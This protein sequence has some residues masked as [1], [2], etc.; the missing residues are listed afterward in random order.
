ML[1]ETEKLLFVCSY[2]APYG[3]NFIPSL[4]A[5]EAKLATRGVRCVYAFPEEAENRS[6]IAELKSKGKEIVYI[7][8]HLSRMRFV[9]KL[10]IIVK[11]KQVN[12]LYAHF[13]S[14]L[15][16]EIFANLH[17][18]IRVFIHIHSDFSA[19][20]RSWKQKIQ[21][22][23]LYKLF[24]SHVQFFSVSSA[25]VDYN[26]KKIFHVP[27]GL[28]KDRLTCEHKGGISVREQ[29]HVADNEILCEIFGWS[30]FIKG[31]DIAVNAVKLLNDRD[32]LP[33]KLAIVGGTTEPIENMKKWI[34]EHTECS[35]NEPYLL[36]FEPSED[37][38]S[39]HEAAD[40][41]LSASRSEGF[42]YSILEMLSI[43][44]RCTI[45]NIMGTEWSQQYETTF[46]FTTEDVGECAEAI[47]KA[48]TYGSQTN[49]AVA[50]KIQNEYSIERWTDNIVEKIRCGQ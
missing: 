50:D 32:M 41:L 21:Q 7:D 36:Y 26:P 44:K 24:A 48:L 2:S 34:A 4:L 20:Q 33:V 31:V 22:F 19:G 27:N 38:F 15:P 39:Y 49:A 25:F 1:K 23:L 10:E 14:I 3:G 11:E 12:I 6:W 28:A 40:I 37:V 43:G 29:H 17:K 5:L 9:K 35:G 16:L 30:Q 13:A 46:A 47:R 45:S 42:S 18:E 8:F